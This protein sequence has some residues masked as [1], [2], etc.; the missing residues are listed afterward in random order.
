LVFGMLLAP[1]ATAA[2]VTRRIGSMVAVSAAIGSASTWLGL[3]LSY[4]HD[5]A[6]GATVV[7]V[8]VGVFVA[9]LLVRG[10]VSGF[11]SAHPSH[12]AHPHPGHGH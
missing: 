7:V 8:A 2:L 5:L 4:H 12:G 6:A 9:A 11:M 10:G 1:A 3:L